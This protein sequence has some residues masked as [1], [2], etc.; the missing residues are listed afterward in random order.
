M[1]GQGGLSLNEVKEPGW[2]LIHPHFLEVSFRN[3]L[4]KLD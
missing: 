3:S 4:A 2:R 1:K